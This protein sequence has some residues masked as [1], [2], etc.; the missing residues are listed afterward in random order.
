MHVHMSDGLSGRLADVYPDVEPIYERVVFA[1]QAQN[2]SVERLFCGQPGHP[3]AP[4][5]N[6]N[7]WR[8]GR[9]TTLPHR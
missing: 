4:S 5:W 6:G 7:P 3:R 1:K 9:S 8:L 2:V